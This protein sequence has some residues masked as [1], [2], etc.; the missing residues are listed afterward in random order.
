MK[1]CGPELHTSF[2]DKDFLDFVANLARGKKVF[3]D[4]IILILI[5]RRKSKESMSIDTMLGFFI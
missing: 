2:C 4:F 1:N 3:Y 5:G